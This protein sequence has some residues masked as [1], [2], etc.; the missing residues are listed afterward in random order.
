MN[1][2]T[3][4]LN[5]IG[6]MCIFFSFTMIPP[7]IVSAW[8]HDGEVRDFS[9]TFLI[10]ISVGSFLW[11]TYKKQLAEL[12][13][14]D[15]FFIVAFFW[16]ILSLVSAIPFMIGPGSLTVIDSIF[17]A[18]SGFTTTGATVIP[19]LE[20][21]HPS[22]LFYRQELQW[23][24]G[25]GLIVFAIAILPMLGVGGSQLYRAEIPGPMKDEKL[26]PRLIQTARSLW[27]IYVV[28]TV[29]CAAAY[30]LSGLNPLDAIEHSFSTVSTG[31][32]STHNESFAFFHS[33]LVNIICVLFML[34]GGINFSVHFMALSN[35]N[36]LLYLKDFEVRSYFIIIL[37]FVLLYTIFLYSTHTFQNFTESLQISLFEVTSVITST[38]FG[39]SDF[40]K[41]PLFLP[42]LLIFISF[43]GG[44][45]GSTAGGLKVIRIL[46]LLKQLAHELFLLIHPKALRP[47]KFGKHILDNKILSATWG[48]LSVYIFVFVFLTLCMMMT[49]LDQVSAFAAIAA[50]INNLGPG[51]GQ[52]SATF[53]SISDP[54]KIIATIAMLMGRLE[55][56]TILIIFTPYY[57]RS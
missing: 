1:R 30:W 17:E 5:T 15:G 7:L 45:G 34:A 38:G 33:N 24:G 31:G 8:Y 16:I 57:W 23:I 28:L 36:P 29:C 51:L 50:C 27:I 21:V 2:R 56:F 53:T 40:S 37:V 48:F 18:T 12:R 9:F 54:A 42:L 39:I 52:V 41:W 43:I 22:I 44:C 46:M 32:F 6:I 13:R 11:L 26:A 55:I 10:L 35:H 14:R 20:T 19:N 4:V 47:I 25:M 49:G 3:V